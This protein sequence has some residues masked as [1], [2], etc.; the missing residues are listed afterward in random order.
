MEKDFIIET[1]KELRS[2]CNDID[3]LYLIQGLLSGEC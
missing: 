3:L 1:I 2:G